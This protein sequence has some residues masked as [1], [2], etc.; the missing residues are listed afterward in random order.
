MTK[1]HHPTEPDQ[2]SQPV[3]E[4]EIWETT[5]RELL[6]AKGII[7]KPELMAQMNQTASQSAAIGAQIIAHAWKDAAFKEALLQNPKST[8]AE[9]GYDVSAMPNLIIV[10]NKPHIHNVVVCTLCSCYPR[11]M[12]GPPPEWY[13][14]AAYRA[15]I[16]KEP[17][18]VLKEFGLSI[19]DDTKICVYD[20]TADL[21]YLV[22]P[23]CPDDVKGLSDEHLSTLITRDTMIGVAVPRLT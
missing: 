19:D 13:K 12:L 14:S 1:H 22:M 8:L 17:R 7:S 10:E 18:E 15:R 9:H 11:Y 20:S 21:R 4:G 23:A 6:L 16:V 2:D 5:L 3:S